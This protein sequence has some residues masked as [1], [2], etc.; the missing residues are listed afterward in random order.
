[1]AGFSEGER[2]SGKGRASGAPDGG[3]L[4]MGLAENAPPIVPV[5]IRTAD[6]DL[7]RVENDDPLSSAQFRRQG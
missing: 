7:G 5:L 1:M 2:E 4:D 6:D 3:I